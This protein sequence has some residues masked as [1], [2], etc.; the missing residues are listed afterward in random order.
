M[1]EVLRLCLLVYMNKCCT[2]IK[3]QDYGIDA[4]KAASILNFKKIFCNNIQKYITDVKSYWNNVTTRR[5]QNESITTHKYIQ[6]ALHIPIY[7]WLSFNFFSSLEMMGFTFY[8]FLI[9]LRWYPSDIFFLL[10]TTVW[11][12]DFLVCLF[13]TLVCCL[14]GLKSNYLWRSWRRREIVG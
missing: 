12:W 8:F 4:V 13:K 9:P 2:E 3:P 10:L 7:Y 6:N 11:F 14:L 1:H 5:T